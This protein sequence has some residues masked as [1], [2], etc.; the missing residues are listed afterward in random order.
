MCSSSQPSTPTSSGTTI[1]ELPEWAKG[2]AKDTLYQASQLTDI[3]KNPYQPYEGQ[4]NAGLSPMQMQAMQGASDM[5]TSNAIG[6]GQNMAGAAGMAALRANYTPSI[7]SNQFNPQGIGYGAQNAQAANLGYAPQISAGQ[8]NA[9]MMG[10][11]QTGYNPNLQNFQMGPAERVRT[12]SFAQP[13]AA[14]AYMS[15]YMQNVVDIQKREAQRQSGIQ[16][17]QQQ[18][19][20]VGAGAFG[21][22][23]DAI[24]RAERERNL[25]QQ[26]G[27]I[28]AQ[29]SQAAYQQAMG[30]FNQEQQA[31]L[32]AQQANQQA[33][34]TVGGQNLNAALGV[35]QL[36]SQTGLQT[37]L[38]NLSSAQQANVQN[39]A[40]Q[41]QTQG[42]N[43][44]Q[45]MQ[46]A[47]ANQQMVGQYGLQ[48]GQY[49][50]QAN[51]ANQAAQNQAGQFNAGQNLQAAGMGA[52][53]GQAAN[54]LNEQSRQYG[55]GYG[56]Q[57]LQTGLQAAGQL[58]TLGQNEYTQ[59]MGI[60]QLQAGY[61]GMQ[62]AQLQK[63]LDTQYGDFQAQMNY[64]YKQLGFMS[65]AIRGL[66]VGTQSANTMY[67]APG[68][69][70][71][72]LG[73]LGVTA[74]G[75][76][77]FMADGGQVQGYAGG[78]SVGA[79]VEN[80]SNIAAIIHQLPDAELQKAAQAAAQRGDKEELRL[81]E[82]EFAMRASL[83]S[84][85]ASVVPSSM[86]G[87]AD[88]GGDVPAGANGGIVAFDKGG[89]T[90]NALGEEID[91]ET[92]YPVPLYRRALNALRDSPRYQNYREMVDNPYGYTGNSGPHPRN[93]P[94][95]DEAPAAV[96]KS[97]TSQR[98]AGD[99]SGQAAAG[100]GKGGGGGGGGKPSGSIS[101]LHPAIAATVDKA[102]KDMAAS[103]KID[104]GSLQ[105]NYK[106]MMD[107][108]SQGNNADLQ[109][110]KDQMTKGDQQ[111][112]ETK[113]QALGNILMA[114]GANWAANASKPGATFMS[115][116]AASA[117]AAQQ[118]MATQDKIVRD[119]NDVQNKIKMDYTKFQ[120]SLKKDDQKTALTAAQ[121]M[122]R[123]NL[124]AAQ[125]REQAAFHGGSIAL[126]GKKLEIMAQTAKDDA[127]N[128]LEHL[129]I[130]R[131]QVANQ[132]RRMDIYDRDAATRAQAV[133][134]REKQLRLNAEKIFANDPENQKY[135]RDLQKTNP[136]DADFL[137]AK[138]KSAFIGDYINSGSGLGLD[139]GSGGIRDL[140][141]Y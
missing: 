20:A 101:D 100:G 82:D 139:S 118:E 86:M 73:G 62:Q 56:L 104:S 63:E 133:G 47:L 99:S 40:A 141:D 28:Q 18:A 116:A 29:G 36:G 136:K 137:M 16:G 9:P 26:M 10:A 70:I 129:G 59:N 126:D 14:D 115:S 135:Y 106:S 80:E 60:N 81:I 17:T 103:S 95:A 109:V 45:A 7:Y 74:L 83:H 49:N 114:F 37:S 131:G 21:G 78:G 111:V 127:Q 120:I 31:R 102:L 3:N 32:A 117:P 87:M 98:P 25:S 75:L 30:Q 42:M 132:S 67:Q 66:P 69:M 138:R 50:Q 71:G 57:G 19:Q 55:A 90:K 112:D 53:Y 108:I 96:S 91:P 52:Q 8:Y 77:K 89:V 124:L 41:L 4:R 1:S 122:E 43:A 35:Q 61:G 54:Q 11:A 123:N 44:Q 22:A 33:G 105:S 39:Q 97:P 51:L 48:Q 128:K 58:G 121:D 65:D 24:Q 85:V 12:Q 34:I 72:Q 92:G 5:Q 76:S 130:L 110:L 140:S 15:P 6:A 27:D 94:S 46:A 13:G 134:V 79:D 64:P 113:G 125:L 93:K 38:A 107:M 119:M 2:Y 23:R 68:S 84:G 88:D